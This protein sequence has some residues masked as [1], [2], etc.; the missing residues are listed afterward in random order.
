M[1]VAMKA[2]KAMKAASPAPAKKEMKA[3]KV[4]FFNIKLTNL[5]HNN[6]L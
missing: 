5:N 3:M 2:M 6:R 1:P 4:T